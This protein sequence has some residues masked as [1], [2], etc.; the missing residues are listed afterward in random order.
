MFVK[1]SYFN[2]NTHFE[3]VRVHY[4]PTRTIRGVLQLC[5]CVVCLLESGTSTLLRL[6]RTGNDR[7]AVS[8]ASDALHETSGETEGTRK[9]LPIGWYAW[10]VATPPTRCDIDHQPIENSPR[11]HVMYI[12]R[13]MYI[14]SHV[15]VG[16]DTKEKDDS[17]SQMQM[18]RESV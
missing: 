5:S 15:W 6:S 7:R 8:A 11:K 18:K 14:I 12:T 17:K 13:C 16:V 1:S 2:G 4:S 10:P 3:S 9:R